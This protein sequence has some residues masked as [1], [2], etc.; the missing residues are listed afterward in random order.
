MALNFEHGLVRALNSA[1]P[2]K[3]RWLVAC[4]GGVDSVALVTALARW[5]RYFSVRLTIAYVHHGENGDRDRA[6]TCVRDLARS[7]KL[8]YVTN[9]S[10]PIGLRSEADFRTFRYR[11]LGRWLRESNSTQLILGH[12]R[13]DL[14]ETQFLRLI[15]GSGP[16][17][18]KAMRLK[19][20]VIMRPL[21]EISRRDVE[22]YAR[23]NFLRWV[24]DPTNAD[25]K[26]LRNWVRH[27]W[28]PRLEAR[29][30][31]ATRAFARSLALLGAA[32]PLH[33]APGHAF[34]L[35]RL[36]FAELAPPAQAAIVAGWLKG[37]GLRDFGTSHVH[38]IC[39]RLRRMR[40]KFAFTLKGCCFHVTPDL[41]WASR[42]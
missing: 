2:G 30:P 16:V 20:G 38:E 6:Q 40:G 13:D 24:E 10:K 1:Q 14:V 18:L 26:H 8:S 17:G 22:D 42:V 29:Q 34:G 39:K 41:V 19:Q 7:L 21:L 35:R 32:E 15:R 5:R 23:K 33:F 4:S 31:G 28:L 11:C 37:L 25:R 3:G 12:H 9:R 27:D 36:F